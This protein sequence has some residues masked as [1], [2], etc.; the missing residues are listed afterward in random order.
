MLRCATSWSARTAGSSLPTAPPPPARTTRTSPR[1]WASPRPPLPPAGPP[2][3]RPPY[4]DVAEFGGPPPTADPLEATTP[5]VRLGDASLKRTR[6]R[7]AEAARGHLDT[8]VFDEL[9]FASSEAVI[10]AQS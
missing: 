3:A 5:S 1:S 10:N 6:R 8:A 4:E 2:P 7:V 9:V